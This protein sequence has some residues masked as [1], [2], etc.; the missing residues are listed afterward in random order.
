MSFSDLP[1]SY[2]TNVHP[3]RTLEEIERGLD[4]YTVPVANRLGTPLAAGLW[5]AAPVIKELQASPQGCRR[6]AEGLHRRGLTCHTLN[7]FPYGDFHSPRVKE[8]VYLPSW[9]EAARLDYTLGAA[10]VLAQ[11]LPA[12]EDGSIST[13]PLGYPGLDSSPAVLARCVDNLIAA[14]RDLD[15]LRQE[16][17]HT[18]RVGLEPEPC[19]WLDTTSSAI[20][21]FATRLWPA[22]RERGCFDEVRNHIGL[23]FDVCHQAVAFEDVGRSIA[24]LDQAGIRLNKIH[25][26]C[27]LELR[28]PATNREGRA[29]LAEYAEPRYLHQTKARLPDGRVLTQ[30]DL[31]PAFA[32][33]PPAEFL[34][35]PVWRT[36]F[37]V[38]VDAER[39]G[40]LA[41]T[42]AELRAALAAVRELPYAPHL[43]VETYTWD[44]MPGSG[45]RNLV[46]G[47]TR[48]LSATQTLLG[49]LS[50][51]RERSPLG[52]QVPD[53][54]P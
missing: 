50:R 49:E 7:A 19:C 18:I 28:E 29:A 13:V 40:P 48:E 44:V 1:L 9:A 4:E 8:N 20:E 51:W 39:L 5:L 30:F 26:T 52:A 54:F 12:S 21:F 37:H 45:P 31:E 43:E 15:R 17:G 23:C 46:D 25:I 6:F 34:E 24:L 32:L 53:V 16:S 33:E 47:L 3:G 36:H 10:R 11:L 35:A 42:R 38:P 14:A 27:A 22:A 2:C 41:T